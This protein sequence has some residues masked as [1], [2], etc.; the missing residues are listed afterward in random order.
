[1][2]ARPA[3][4]SGTDAA[5]DALAA[6]NGQGGAALSAFRLGTRDPA[7]RKRVAVSRAKPPTLAAGPGLDAGSAAALNRLLAAEAKANALVAAS[8]KALWRARTARARH[9]RAATRRQLRASA[10]FAAQAASALKRLPALRTSAVNALKAGGVAEVIANPDAVGAFLSAVR[11][12]GLPS[13]LTG[14]LTRLGL[15][16][17]DLKHVRAGVLDQTA[18]GAS[19]PVLIASLGDPNRARTRK[20]LV[21]EMSAYSLRARRHRLAR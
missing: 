20:T 13:Y 4:L 19:G 1:L 12:S 10:K 3:Q 11:R 5:L 7:Y 15:G 18:S 14:P 2:F 21:K 9:D 6:V 16:R 8:A 17:A